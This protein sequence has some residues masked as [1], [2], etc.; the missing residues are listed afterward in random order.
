MNDSKS[1]AERQRVN[2]ELDHQSNPRI[3]MES[4]MFLILTQILIF[5]GGIAT[6]LFVVTILGSEIKTDP[7]VG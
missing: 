3:R 7:I 1:N 2:L 4:V 5:G 6:A